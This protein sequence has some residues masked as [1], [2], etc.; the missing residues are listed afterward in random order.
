MPSCFGF[1]RGDNHVSNSD[2]IVSEEALADP[3]G[4]VRHPDFHALLQESHARTP[5]ALQTPSLVTRVAFFSTEESKENDQELIKNLSAHKGFKLIE[6]T[7]NEAQYSCSLGD[8]SW[9][10]HTEFS[11]LTLYQ[12]HPKKNQSFSIAELVKAIWPEG[13]LGQLL[14][15]VQIHVDGK[16]EN[17][18][19]KDWETR[20]SENKNAC[21]CYV[22]DKLTIVWTDLTPQPDGMIHYYVSDRSGRTHMLGRTAQRLLDVEIYRTLS[23]LSMPLARRVGPR[24]AEIDRQI[25]E[26]ASDLSKKTQ[27][28]AE[29]LLERLTSIAAA[30]EE[31][32]VQMQFRLNASLAYADI[33]NF[34]LTGLRESKLEGHQRLSSYILRR[35]KPANRT[36]QAV[37]ERLL[38][39]SNRI[40]RISSLL[41]ARVD[42]ALEKQNQGL[43]QSMDRRATQQLKLQRTVE[44]LS[45]IAISYYL[46]GIINYLIKPLKSLNVLPHLELATIVI[47]PLAVLYVWRVV[48]RIRNEHKPD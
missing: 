7:E 37:K 14:T 15:A 21:Q 27:T 5:P 39:M 40:A 19:W 38:D 3:D 4:L 34:R 10:R 20:T 35:L 46:I 26:I 13:S 33:V 12:N 47:V 30:L 22:N 44:G 2:P 11:T 25:A 41:R 23:L 29:D 24:M 28:E 31:I 9:Q 1:E 48:H 8:V 45:V 6:A 36:F 32:S 18:W 16:D 43:L 17:F 42:V